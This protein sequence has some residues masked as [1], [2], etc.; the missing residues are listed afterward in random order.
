MKPG[1]GNRELKTGSK[2]Y[3]ARELE[4]I[5]MQESGLYSD[6]YFSKESGGYYAVENSTK[7][8]TD[9]EINAARFLANKGYKVVLKDEAGQMTTPDGYIYKY[10]FEQRT[11][12]GSSSAN[13]VTS[14]R[15]ARD[16]KADIAI[17]YMKYNRHTKQSVVE[18]LKAYE[19]KSKYRFKQIIIITQDGRL[20]IHKHN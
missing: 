3:T 19:K 13:F 12:E 8:K 1:G 7:M 18:G 9:E 5:K 20:H 6:V 10:S 15:H 4:V 16:K 2:E 17:V 14:L 11:P